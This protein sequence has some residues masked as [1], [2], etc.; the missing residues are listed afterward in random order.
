VFSYVDNSVQCVLNI[1]LTEDN[2]NC[3]VK[4]LEAK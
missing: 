3:V 1:P 4:H 2:Y